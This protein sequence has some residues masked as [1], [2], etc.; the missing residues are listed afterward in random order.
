MDAAG[1]IIF[2]RVGGHLEPQRFLVSGL[3]ALHVCGA[4][5][6]ARNLHAAALVRNSEPGISG[7]LQQI[8]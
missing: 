3:G 2:F 5:S 4:P 8:K 6:C 1:I 7:F